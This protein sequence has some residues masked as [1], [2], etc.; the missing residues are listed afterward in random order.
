MTAMATKKSGDPL[1]DFA[2]MWEPFGGA[3]FEEVFVKFGVDMDEYKRRLFRRLTNPDRA[4]LIDAALRSRFIDYSV[5][6][7]GMTQ[8]PHR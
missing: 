7:T 4:G 1:V 3:P 2:A 8:R 6:A 5:H